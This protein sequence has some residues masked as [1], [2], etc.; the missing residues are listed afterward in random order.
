MADLSDSSFTAVND[1]EVAQDAAITEALFTKLGQNLNYL[2]TNLDAEVA[3]SSSSTATLDARIDSFAPKA[4]RKVQSGATDVS[5]YFSAGAPVIVTTGTTGFSGTN[6][7][8]LLI[9]S[10]TTFTDPDVTG[11]IPA[12]SSNAVDTTVSFD[13]ARHI[14]AS[15]NETDSKVYWVV[16]EEFTP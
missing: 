16:Y 6:T 4:F 1:V 13:T 9:T 14:T 7:F 11:A 8:Y 2:K 10:F 5:S 3:S 15:F 12:I